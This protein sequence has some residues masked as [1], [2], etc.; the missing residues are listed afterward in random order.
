MPSSC[1]QNVIVII[2]STILSMLSFMTILRRRT[3]ERRRFLGVNLISD[4]PG[5]EILQN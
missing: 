2:L 5:V 4:G 1:E 3:D